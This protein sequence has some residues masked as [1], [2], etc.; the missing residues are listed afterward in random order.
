M[1]EE[2]Y[3]ERGKA[4]AKGY[5][6]GGG[7]GQCVSQGGVGKQCGRGKCREWCNWNGMRQT[8]WRVVTGNGERG[9]G[10][11]GMLTSA[12]LRREENAGFEEVDLEKKYGIYFFFFLL[13]NWSAFVV[14]VATLRLGFVRKGGTGEGEE[15]GDD[16]TKSWRRK[17][18]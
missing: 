16:H 7:K 5:F 2:G 3:F 10:R 12:H 14:L 9:T 4:R 13:V 15:R 8:S 18:R 1:R 11:C 17:E 6:E